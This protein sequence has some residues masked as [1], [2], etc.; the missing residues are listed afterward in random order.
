MTNDS[1]QGSFSS[2]ANSPSSLQAKM[3]KSPSKLQRDISILRD[4]HETLSAAAE[5][6]EPCP[7]IRHTSISRS[8]HLRYKSSFC[9]WLVENTNKTSIKNKR[10]RHSVTLERTNTLEKFSLVLLFLM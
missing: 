3:K 6:S 5:I 1:F 2:I 9:V 10:N 8:S 4:P 7:E